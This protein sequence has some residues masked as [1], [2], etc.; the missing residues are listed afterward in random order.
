MFIHSVHNNPPPSSVSNHRLPS[1]YHLHQ[2]SSAELQQQKTAIPS[3]SLLEEVLNNP[4][5]KALQSPS[6]PL[7]NGWVSQTS[8]GT[9]HHTGTRKG[10]DV[11]SDLLS[12]KMFNGEAGNVSSLPVMKSKDSA[13]H[14]P[15]LR[16]NK[17]HEP[18]P[19]MVNGVFHERPGLIKNPKT[20]KS[21]K[22][23]QADCNEDGEEDDEASTEARLIESA[24]LFAH[25]LR[26][27]RN[28]GFYYTR[29]R[30][31]NFAMRNRVFDTPPSASF[32]VK[33]R[34]MMDG[35]SERR[36]AML[37][38][39]QG[40]VPSIQQPPPPPPP[41]FVCEWSGCFRQFSE[42]SQVRLPLDWLEIFI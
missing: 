12:M 8:G 23:E 36:A 37:T 6:P 24:T 4:S 17:K 7:V 16:V 27:N 5:E 40:K 18:S 32:S 3:K 13:K 26:Y 2:I 15:L 39:E 41:M 10:V 34:K 38:V 33:R 21:L 1:R 22:K 25:Q 28:V 9:I 20:L 30:P 35:K 29:K 19:L 11:D 14:S 31:R 42:A